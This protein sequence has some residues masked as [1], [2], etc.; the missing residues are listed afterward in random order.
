MAQRYHAESGCIIP[1]MRPA[2]SSS[3]LKPKHPAGE[4]VA[5]WVGKGCCRICLA[6]AA[7]CMSVVRAQF[8]SERLDNLLL[9][10]LTAKPNK[11]L[12]CSFRSVAMLSPRTH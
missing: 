8:E 3:N 4:T 10:V 11:A 2:R 6:T 1:K 9:K 7:Q 5:S 12:Y